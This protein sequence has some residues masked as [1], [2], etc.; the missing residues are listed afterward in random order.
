[1]AP[2]VPRP[3]FDPEIHALV[4]DSMKD[5]FR[6]GGLQPLRD[7]I[8]NLCTL[9]SVT[10]GTVFTHTERSVPSPDGPDAAPITLSVFTPKTGESG[11]RPCI[12]F[13]HSGGVVIGNRFTSFKDSLDWGETTNAVVITTEYR[14]APEHP[15]PAGLNDCWAA[16]NWIHYHAADLG[17]DATRVAVTGQSAGA[18]MATAV[19]MMA[20]EKGGPKIAA[21]LIDTGMMDDRGITNSAEQFDEATVTLDR[22]SNDTCWDAH[23]GKLVRGSDDVPPYA[24]PNRATDLSGFPPT[25][26]D[27]GGSEFARDDN[28]DFAR[29]L[30]K[31]GVET[32]LHVWTGAPHGFTQMAPEASL[33][34]EARRMRGNWLKRIL[35]ERPQLAQ[36]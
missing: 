13:M 2:D 26:V 23:L 5:Y 24:A 35:V 7:M 14:L 15:Y 17:I 22:I 9:E 27:C 3:P 1:M 12:F 29:K 20:K 28:I 19:T 30:M 36:S 11:N 6:P 21:L 32:E 34:R 8:E 31:C 33:S 10:D 25:Y 4:G 18:L 16:F